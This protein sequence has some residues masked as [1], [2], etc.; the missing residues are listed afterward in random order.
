VSSDARTPAAAGPPSEENSEFGCLPRER[1]GGMA[2]LTRE[3]SAS[4]EVVRQ[5][6]A[7]LA[8]A[9]YDTTE[10]VATP[11]DNCARVQ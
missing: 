5:A 4:P 10:L 8:L 9:G 7:S 2:I 1:T 3:R 11:Q 6:R